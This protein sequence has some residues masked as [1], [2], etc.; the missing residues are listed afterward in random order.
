MTSAER[1]PDADLTRALDHRVAE[2]RKTPIAAS[3]G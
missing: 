1:K 2:R 3:A